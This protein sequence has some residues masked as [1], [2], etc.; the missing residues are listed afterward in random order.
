ML[1]PPSSSRARKT[2]A[3][4]STPLKATTPTNPAATARTVGIDHSCRSP[5]TISR[6]HPTGGSGSVEPATR[7]APVIRGSLASRAAE[8]AKVATSTRST[9]RIP[10]SANSAAAISGPSASSPYVPTPRAAL[11]AS[12]SSSSTTRGTALR[13]AAVKVVAPIPRAATRTSRSGSGGSDTAIASTRSP[14]TTSQVTI[15]L[16]RPYLSPIMPATGPNRPGTQSPAS[17]SSATA[18]AAPVSACR[19]TS[20]ATRPRESPSTETARADHSIRNPR[21][22]RS[23]RSAPPRR[24]RTVRALS[25]AGERPSR[26]RRQRRCIRACGGG[27]PRPTRCAGPPTPRHWPRPRSAGRWRS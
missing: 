9:P 10:L 12:R 8:T 13:D 19:Y 2:S 27:S 17:N 14:C 3:T 22:R 25:A 16:R 21:L 5:V 24:G 11:A 1:E 6:H 20:S 26:A 18:I 7:P 23:S 4:S 15:T